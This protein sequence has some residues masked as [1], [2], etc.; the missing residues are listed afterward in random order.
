MA[1]LIG[2]LLVV[3]PLQ[4]DDVVL[5]EKMNGGLRRVLLLLTRK[6]VR[7]ASAKATA[8]ASSNQ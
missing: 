7:A 1:L 4:T 5:L 6:S 2:S 3:K 8:E